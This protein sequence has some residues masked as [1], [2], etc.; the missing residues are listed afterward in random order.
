FIGALLRTIVNRRT[1]LL[2]CNKGSIG[3]I[4]DKPSYNLD[5][6]KTKLYS[7]QTRTLVEFL[8]KG[9][10]INTLLKIYPPILRFNPKYINTI[11]PN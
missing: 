1:P 10:Y 11:T 9:I 5:V 2:K 4:I 3:K 6:K 7:M 8:E